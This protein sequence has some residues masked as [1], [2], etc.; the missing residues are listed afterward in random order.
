MEPRFREN[1]ELLMETAEKMAHD[2]EATYHGCP[3]AVLGAVMRTLGMKDEAVFR[4]SLPLAGGFGMKQGTCGAIAGGAMALGLASDKYGR[5]WSQHDKW[6]IDMLLESLY[7]T[8]KYLDRVE[9]EV[10]TL[11]CK[12]ITEADFS[13]RAGVDAYIASPGFEASCV[14]CGKIARI[15]VEMIIEES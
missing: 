5:S 12:E 3:Q 1:K 2:F 11:S 13:T 15:V 7:L 4:A 9:K 8:G 14:A 10:G 6:D